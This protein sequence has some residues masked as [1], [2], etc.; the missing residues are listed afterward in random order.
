LLCLGQPWLH[1]E[2]FIKKKEENVEWKPKILAN[3]I[4][5]MG[6]KS[7][8]NF[9]IQMEWYLAKNESKKYSLDS[10]GPCGTKPW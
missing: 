6:P 3:D 10:Y 9:L 8:T 5:V 1:D 2:I 4:E 7:S